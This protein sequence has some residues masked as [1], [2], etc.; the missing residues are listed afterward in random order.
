MVFDPLT[1]SLSGK[2]MMA[3]SLGYEENQGDRK[4]PHSPPGKP[5]MTK[6]LGYEEN[7]G[8]RKGPHSPP[9]KRIMTK[10]LG[11]EENQGDR[12]GPHSPPLHPRPYKDGEAARSATP[13][14]C[15]G[16]GGVVGSGDPCGR[17]GRI[18]SMCIIIPLLC[19]L[20]LLLLACES[21]PASTTRSRHT[22][23]TGGGA[24]ISYAAGAQDVVIRTFYGGGRLGTLELSPEISIYGDGSYI[25]GPGL[26]M[27]EGQLSST[28]LDQLLLTLVDRDGL[29]S[30]SQQQFYDIPDQNATF[31]QLNINQRSYN[32]VYG[33]FGNLPESAQ[34]MAEYRQL[35]NALTSIRNAL[36][37]PLHAYQGTRMALLVHQDFSPDLSQAIPTWPLS[38]IDLANLAI[39]ECGAIPQDIT[40]PNAD[41]GCLTYTVPQ[42]ALLLTAQQQQ[43][44]L[45][46]LNGQKQGVFLEGGVYYAVALRELLPDELPAKMLAMLGSDE[47]SYAG[48]PL[49][50]GPVPTP[51]PTP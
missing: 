5:M 50:S 24:N 48:I 9:G 3:K 23:S 30:F 45:S 51:V 26:S 46:L 43:S 34:E 14:L 36:A 33:P 18:S 21:T 19:L 8:D 4:G 47:L 10:S 25:L 20:L 6:S 49:S 39:Y 28:A 2:R 40:G 38:D 13:S 37:G 22:V 44:V 32:F 15:K 12:K 41:T 31:L 7:Q 17:P 11:Y 1:E 35:G 29:L 42:H 16:G 27:Q